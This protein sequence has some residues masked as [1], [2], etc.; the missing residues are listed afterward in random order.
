MGLM[1]DA[2]RPPEKARP[3]TPLAPR[4]TPGTKG[5]T[6]KGPQKKTPEAQGPKIID[7]LSRD[8]K[9]FVTTTLINE[10]K[11]IDALTKAYIQENAEFAKAIQQDIDKLKRELKRKETEAESRRKSRSGRRSWSGG[12]SW[13]SSRW[14]DS[15]GRYG[16]D[17]SSSW[18]GGRSSWS[19]SS[20]RWSGSSRSHWG[21]SSNWK[22]SGS[23]WSSDSKASG[24]GPAY[25]H[26]KDS[27]AKRDETKNT[28]LDSNEKILS[29]LRRLSTQL[30]RD[31]MTPQEQQAARMSI[32]RT[33]D[34]QQLIKHL[35]TRG[36][37]L[38]RYKPEEKNTYLSAEEESNWRTVLPHIL[39]MMRA[40]LTS[41]R[42]GGASG[43]MGATILSK[44]KEQYPPA[45]GL[46]AFIQDQVAA[47]EAQI[48][49][50][51]TS[52][53]VISGTT[54][55]LPAT[56]TPELRRIAQEISYLP[57]SN[58]VLIEFD[59]QMSN[60]PTPT[61]TPA[62]A[63]APAA[64]APAAAPARVPPARH[65]GDLDEDSSGEED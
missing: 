46:D 10:H 60:P 11:I 33:G 39:I 16:R 57:V 26:S 6:K 25:Q 37:I 54:V 62:P 63:P 35:E 56:I 23:G 59:E 18:R 29:A 48:I 22:S 47:H 45:R 64:R 40:N 21:D 42:G 12:R 28:L 13:G 8:E 20:S 52:L 3:K 30:N 44:L 34:L 24:S 65:L 53:G 15:Y 5:A 2:D 7:T 9:E 14:G 31:N 17:S 41:R 36:E 38:A 43:E 32:V 61:A 50:Q 27:D 49:T 4:D 55:R 51:L 58:P 19:P 1:D